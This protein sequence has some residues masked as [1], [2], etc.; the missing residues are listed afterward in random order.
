MCGIAGFVGAGD[1]DTL[2][3]MAACLAHRGP[4]GQGLHVDRALRVFLAHRR[5]AVLDIEGGLQP[6]WNE[7][8]SVCV[9]FNG[10]IYNHAELRSDLLREG[11]IFKSDHSDTEVLVHGW[12][13]WGRDLP[14]K[15]NGMFSFAVLDTNARRL[16]LARD[17]FGEKPLY[18]SQAQDAFLFASEIG[19]LLHHPSF[20]RRYDRLSLKKY[21]AFGYF[22]APNT[23]YQGCR[24]LP[25]GHHL[26]LNLDTRA[27][28]VVSFWRFSL[29][30]DDGLT[31]RSEG[32]L[33]DELQ[34]L[35][36]Q[37]VRRR[38]VSDV[39]LGIFL[40]GGIDSSAILA[41]AA[42]IRDP[43]TIK[44]FTIGFQEASF[45]ESVYA[46]TVARSIGTDHQ[47]RILSI[48]DARD[49]IGEVL[50]RLDEPLGDPSILPTY[51]LSRFTREQVTVALSGDGGD[52]LFAGYDPF[53]ALAAS[54]VYDLVMPKL[55][56]SGVRSLASML[57]ISTRNM[58]LDFKIRRALVGV[59]HSE[60]VRAAAWMGPLEP[61]EIADLFDEPIR[62]EDLY[63]EAIAIWDANAT[64]SRVDRLL[65]FFTRLYLPDNILTK[66]DRATMMASLESRAIFLDND[67]VDFCIRLP[68]R[69]KYRKGARKYLL[70]KA[71]APLL[72]RDIIERRKKGFGI[73]TSDWLRHVPR[74]PPLE[75]LAGM[76]LRFA[77]RRWAQH[78]ARTHDHR[79]FLWCWMTT[80]FSVAGPQAI[81]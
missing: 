78:R 3:S 48:N 42:K 22:P 2:A 69:F 10:E 55:L 8:S 65:E 14:S 79:L 71:V 40:S 53:D 70:K 15:L 57:P 74:D 17:R 4:D 33:V 50:G 75:P 59:T 72:P 16:F 11:H 5:L 39:P 1:R 47:E 27:V 51:V 80:Q 60:N 30:P 19:S 68:N 62:T 6:M 29:Q 9:V 35:L 37:A 49:L 67:L 12:E 46:Q 23:L 64:G 36:A 34:G 66:A 25:A 7:D 41:F 38:L 76:D 20:D 13:Q 73:P 58:S 24:K 63:S 56:H 61:K 44:T 31:D 18:Y 52:E 45:D 21:F 26:T 28:D 32:R 54:R 77:S 81:V 43:S